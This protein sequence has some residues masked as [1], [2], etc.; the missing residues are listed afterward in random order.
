MVPYMADNALGGVVQGSRALYPYAKKFV[1]KVFGS[2]TNMATYLS[3][4]TGYGQKKTK[5][6]KKVSS[7]RNA[8]VQSEKSTGYN[9][10][11]IEKKKTS[12]SKR[13]TTRISRAL[14]QLSASQ[15]KIISRWNAV[16]NFQNNGFYWLSNKVSGTDRLLPLYT[17]DLT[18]LTN[19]GNNGFIAA[20]PCSQMLQ[21]NTGGISFFAKEHYDA[22]GATLITTPQL[23]LAPYKNS[24]TAPGSDVSAVMPHNY[25]YLKWASIKLNCWGCKNRP[26]KF[27]IQLVKVTDPDITPSHNYPIN[28]KRTSVFQNLIKAKTFNPISTT[29]ASVQSKKLKVLKSETFTIQPTSSYETDTD[30][31]CKTINWFVRIDKFIKYVEKAKVLTTQADT[32]DQADYVLNT[33]EQVSSYADPRARIYVLVTSTNFAVDATDN[34]ADTPSFDMSVRVCHEIN[35]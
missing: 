6:N 29:G 1:R 18:A 27:T 31:H 13:R 10:W 8:M 24:A 12:L 21:N 26:T 28:D 35:A 7:K 20:Q 14:K 32:L 22:D 15:E 16:K 23:E 2:P 33:G 25:S 9:Q 5:K 3:K 19:Y 34:N 30:P 11:E 17:F 4:K